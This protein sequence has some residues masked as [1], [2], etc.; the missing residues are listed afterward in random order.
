MPTRAFA[1]V[2][3]V[4]A[5]FTSAPFYITATVMFAALSSVPKSSKHKLLDL[6][7]LNRNNDLIVT[8]CIRVIQ[9]PLLGAN[10][11]PPLSAAPNS[12]PER[13]AR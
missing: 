9:P 3:M 7:A 2:E 10:I 6:H 11:T 8:R 1:Y 5:C 13:L 4:R 12:E